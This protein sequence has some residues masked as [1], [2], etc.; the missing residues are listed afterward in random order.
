MGRNTMAPSQ[1]CHLSLGHGLDHGFQQARQSEEQNPA[2]DWLIT[3][4]RRAFTKLST[5]QVTGVGG[6][7]ELD[8]ASALLCDQPVSGRF[9]CPPVPSSL[10]ARTEAEMTLLTELDTMALRP[11]G[12]RLPLCCGMHSFKKPRAAL[13]PKHH[14]MAVFQ[15]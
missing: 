13:K 6:C 10:K 2:K 1:Q 11:S 5:A 15:Q 12:S 4:W 3:E 9:C 14:T 8:E 7:A